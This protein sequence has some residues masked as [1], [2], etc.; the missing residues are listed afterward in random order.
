MRRSLSTQIHGTSTAELYAPTTSPLRSLSWK[1]STR[2]ATSEVLSAPRH[3]GLP[4]QLSVEKPRGEDEVVV[5]D[6]PE[7]DDEQDEGEIG[8]ELADS[9][10]SASLQYMAA[11]HL[12]NSSDSLLG[13]PGYSLGLSEY[14]PNPLSDA[15]AE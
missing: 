4:A 15:G 2:A 7:E 11:M 6:E 3:P 9:G 13:V 10:G 12:T 14:F 1:G 5:I 8:A